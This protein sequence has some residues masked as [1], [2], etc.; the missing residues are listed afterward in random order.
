MK[1]KQVVLYASMAL[2]VA[3][4]V[5]VAWPRQSNVVLGQV[6][7]TAGTFAAASTKEGATTE[8]TW[9]ADSASG[10]LLVYDYDLTT[11]KVAVAMSRN[12]RKDMEAAQ[13]GNL[14]LVPSQISDTRGLMYVVDTSSQH[15]VVYEYSRANG[16]AGG[17][18]V[19]LGADLHP[20]APAANAGG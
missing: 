3:L 14:M 19:D 20:A 5:L 10:T 9:I 15:M 6:G 4:L 1:T 13:L 7:V 16:F 18:Q 12:L 17:Q 11:R 8:A 2:N